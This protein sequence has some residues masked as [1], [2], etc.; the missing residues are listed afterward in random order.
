MLVIRVHESP[1]VGGGPEAGE[2]AGGVGGDRV[3]PVRV[4]ARDRDAHPAEVAARRGQP[5]AEAGPGGAA[6][7][8]AVDAGADA[9]VHPALR[10][11][12]GGPTSRRRPGSAWP[13]RSRRRPRR[14]W[15]SRRRAR[16]ARS[17]RRPWCGTGRARRP[18]RTGCRWRRRRCGWRSSGRSRAGRCARCRPGPR[19][20]QVAPPSARAVDA[21]AGERDAAAARVALAGAGV[22]RAGRRDGQRPDRRGQRRPATRW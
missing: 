17:S 21:V 2:V 8:R 12:G 5:A 1:R 22:E 15:R 19:W 16:A 11:A 10:H 18:A 6:V 9:A 13:G 7:G 20:V 4:A 3:Q 14:W